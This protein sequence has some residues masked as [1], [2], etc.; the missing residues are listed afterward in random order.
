MIFG[1]YVFGSLYI[2]LVFEKKLF[3]N[4]QCLL[5]P[6]ER[7]IAQQWIDSVCIP[8]TL[9]MKLCFQLTISN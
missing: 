3:I 7:F 1:I 9:F 6:G 2:S 5:T 4:F 8:A